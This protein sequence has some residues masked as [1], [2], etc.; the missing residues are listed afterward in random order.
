MSLEAYRAELRRQLAVLPALQRQTIG[1]VVAELE[2][3]R[4][5]IVAELA[6]GLS[7]SGRATRARTLA[8]IERQLASWTRAANELGGA[9]AA[10][11]WRHGLEL[12]RAPLG[13][14]G[15]GAGMGARIDA[16]ALASIQ[17]VLTDRISGASTEAIQRINQVL[18]QTMIGTTSQS[19]AITQIG[20]IL[21]STRRRAQT[22]L[23]TELGRAHAMASHAAM[24]EAAELLPGLRKRWMRSGKRYPR[25]DHAAAHNQIV[26]VGEP[27][28]VGG[29]EMLHPRDP[30][31]PARHTINCGCMAVP[32]VDGSTFG[33][34]TQRIDMRNPSVAP[35][36]ELT[37]APLAPVVPVA[38]VAP[39]MPVPPPVPVPTAPSATVSA[40]LG[41]VSSTARTIARDQHPRFVGLP[42]Q[43]IDALAGWER[44]VVGRP[45]EHLAIVSVDGRILQDVVGEADRV[46]FTL[47]Y[48]SGRGAVLTHTHRTNSAPGY[49]DVITAAAYEVLELRVI[50]PRDVFRV[51]PFNRFTM[52]LLVTHQAALAAELRAILHR[53]DGRYPGLTAEQRMTVAYNYFF[54]LVAQRL[55]LPHRRV[56]HGY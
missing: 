24:L 45:L 7:D 33:A 15:L 18:L 5:R 14:A 49:R 1:L 9:A 54:P 43:V 23:F 36:R 25:R 32:V 52:G 8:E 11:S 39:V 50:G 21:G 4:A 40:V 29:V 41:A 55:Q 19:D 56:P 2:R 31:A 12:V 47:P 34:S 35:Q 17:R 37:S 38:P 48:D 42:S 46:R 10:R 53:I 20:E 51:G 26:L 27:F 13:A 28:V 44:S 22:I 30:A 3:A 6:G 16:R